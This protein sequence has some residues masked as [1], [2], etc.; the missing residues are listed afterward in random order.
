MSSIYTNAVIRKND[1]LLRGV[2]NGK[3]YKTKVRYQPYLFVESNSA[4][5]DSGYRTLSNRRVEK[6]DFDSIWDAREYLRKYQNIQNFPV[7]GID[8]FVYPFLNDSFPDE[9]E[10]DRR[11]INVAN[12][13]IET[14]MGLDTLQADKEITSITLKCKDTIHVFSTGDY[15][16]K[17]K[18]VIYHKCSDE[19]HMLMR[20]MNVWHELDIDIV[21]GW[22]IEFYDI[23]YLINRIERILGTGQSV[24]LSP[25]NEPHRSN[26]VEIFVGK[27]IKTYTITG[28][29]TLDY[30][31]LYKKY[32]F[33]NQE[34]YKLDHI[35]HIV[36][37]EKKLDYSEYGNLRELFKQNFTKYIDYNIRDVLLVDKLDE[38]LGLIDQA[39]TI[40]YSSKVNYEDVF[41]SVGLWDVIIHNYLLDNGIVVPQNKYQQKIDTLRG[42]YVKDPQIGGYGWL[43]S[44]DI[45][46]LYPSLIVQ[47]NISPE[48]YK[49]KLPQN[50]TTDELLDGCI[51]AH[52]DLLNKSNV[53]VTANSCLWDKSR[54]GAFPALIEKMMGERKRYRK[55]MMDAK[56]EYEQN[57]TLQ[58][59]RDIA[60][61]NNMQ[62][63]RKILMNS[64]Y[65][66]LG[67]PGCR[68]FQIDFAE[69]ITI[70]G[71]MVITNCERKLNQYFNKL[72]KTT[73]ANYIIAVDTDS[74]YINFDPLVKQ[75]NIPADKAVDFIDKACED[76]IEP[77]LD[78]CF[79]ELATYTN[80]YTNFMKMKREVIADRGIWTGKKHYILNVWDQ[81]GIRFSEPKL[82]LVG[83]EAV[84]SSSSETA[85]SMIKEA[86]K[87][88]VFG[89]ETGVQDY[90]IK[91]RAKFKE[92]PVEDIASPRSCNGM[93]TYRDKDSIYGFKTPI[94]VRGALLFNH[95]L[96]EMDLEDIYAPIEDGDKIKFCY[97]KLPNPIRED[98]IAFPQVLPKEMGLHAFID[99]N[100]QFDKTVLKPIETLLSAIGWHSE[101][102]ITLDALFG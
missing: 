35:C 16:S 77:Y 86:I 49:G 71:Q 25:W 89:T 85:R 98:V 61:F 62:M 99:H 45:N 30:M 63:A 50:Y 17:N 55:L 22:N 39:L 92:L 72:L 29:S 66:T 59:E 70:S 31:Q 24:K 36:L 40:A 42:A 91:A 94:N 9:I 3:R 38:K 58:L 7:Y 48:T 67:N 68:W 44:F 54:K 19:A 12:L 1:I 90:I 21:T 2:D 88:M 84:K 43:A 102:T 56:K 11:D 18:N 51:D 4:I 81:E 96:K 78:T 26:D 33:T 5:K 75:L 65:G 73:A 47:Y 32:S 83:I 46:S 80:A 20:F 10:F 76:K 101:E 14:D 53:S 6:I 37:G 28:I 87:L 34:S 93:R 52:R 15:T 95:Y 8:R 74:N 57:P 97:L 64:L 41:T 13:D 69:A 82:K 23:P 27:K 79:S 100:L 60:R